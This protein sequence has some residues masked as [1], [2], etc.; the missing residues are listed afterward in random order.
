MGTDGEWE[1]RVRR[2]RRIERERRGGTEFSLEERRN[3]DERSKRIHGAGGSRRDESQDAP[4]VSVP[5]LLLLKNSALSVFF[6]VA[7]PAP[8]PVPEPVAL[9]STL[10]FLS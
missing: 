10:R 7:S 9:W 3:G 6:S 1:R 2:E 4:F 5:P 8:E